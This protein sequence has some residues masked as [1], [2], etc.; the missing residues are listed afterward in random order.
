MRIDKVLLE[1]GLTYITMI[2]LLFDMYFMGTVGFGCGVPMIMKGVPRSN[3]HG[4]K[5]Q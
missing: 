5:H 1:H 3:S 2:A 4:K